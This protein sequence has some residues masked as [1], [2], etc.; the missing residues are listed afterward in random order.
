MDS[1][2]FHIHKKSVILV[3]SEKGYIAA[4]E[5]NALNIKKKGIQ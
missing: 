4:N 2:N 5:R 1:K 3:K